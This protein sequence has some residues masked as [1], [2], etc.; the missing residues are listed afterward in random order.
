[1]VASCRVRNEGQCQFMLN[2][3]GSCII[4]FACREVEAAMDVKVF[5]EGM[6]APGI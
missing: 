5:V 2:L 1:M 4:S 3:L 6:L